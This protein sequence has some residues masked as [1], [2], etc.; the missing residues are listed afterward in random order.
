[1]AQTVDEAVIRYFAERGYQYAKARGEFWYLSVPY[2]EV[3]KHPVETFWCA[4][5][6]D[7]GAQPICTGPDPITCFITAELM[8]WQQT[9]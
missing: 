6:T 8:G 5:V 9:H 3:Y 2:R 1:M 7:P 4:V